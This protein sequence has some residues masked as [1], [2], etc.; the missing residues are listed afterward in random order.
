MLWTLRRTRRSL[1]LPVQIAVGLPFPKNAV[2]LEFPVDSFLDD[3]NFCDNAV[4]QGSRSDIKGRVP[5]SSPICGGTDFVDAVVVHTSRVIVGV[6]DSRALHDDHLLGRTFLDDDIATGLGVEIYGRPGRCNQ[7]LD[8]VIP[9]ENRQGISANLVCR[10]AVGCYPI[11]PDDYR[12]N[13]LG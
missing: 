12:R 9:S 7:E 8:I 2:Q 1:A 10:V 13:V 11:G 6:V 5:A 4:D 3:A